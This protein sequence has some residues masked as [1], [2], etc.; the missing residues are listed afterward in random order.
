[1]KADDGA[2]QRHDAEGISSVPAT[3]VGRV[4][5]V[6]RQVVAMAP[7]FLRGDIDAD[8]MANTMVH[9]ARSYVEQEQAT[10]SDGAPHDAEAEALQGALTELM[11]CGSGYL[12]NRCDAACVARTMSEM[13]REFGSGQSR[14]A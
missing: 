14:S 5:A 11:A 7:G 8:Q 9:A 12:A 10:G 6:I 13:V 4:H 2:E 1:M 3:Q